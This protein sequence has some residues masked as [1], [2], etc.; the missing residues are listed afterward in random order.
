MTHRS[1]SH[2]ASAVTLPTLVAS[3]L[4][5]FVV[6]PQPNL[7]ASEGGS[8]PP[9]N[10]SSSPQTSAQTATHKELTAIVLTPSGAPAANADAVIAVPGTKV[11]IVDG[12][13]SPR[14]KVP[15]RRKTD[16]T[17]RFAFSPPDGDFW[18]VITHNTGFATIKGSPNSDANRL[19]LSPW[20]RVEG[21]FRVARK[22]QPNAKIQLYEFDNPT[23]AANAPAVFIRDLQKTD[24]NGR[25]VFERVVPGRVRINHDFE[26]S[27]NEGTTKLDS[28]FMVPVLLAAGESKKLDFGGS[29]RPVVGQLRRSAEAK[30]EAPWNFAF[31]NVT[32][33]DPTKR[34]MG[35]DFTGTVDR[36]GNFCID[37]VPPGNY[38]LFAHFSKRASP[39]RVTNHRFVVPPIDEKLSQ[40]PVD[41][42]VLTMTVDNAF[43]VK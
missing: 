43:E 22:L 2:G 36:R 34:A 40:R 12:A 5:L 19:K 7:S 25:F 28:G 13:I 17:G 35:P 39:G 27:P 16:S 38:A 33:E 32:P 3:L 26:F 21:V 11:A 1:C 42:G 6:C 18:F 37:D 30:G 8:V 9:Q 4:T 24:A 14:L 23:V 31:V 29:G 41:L 20:A 10:D 15:V